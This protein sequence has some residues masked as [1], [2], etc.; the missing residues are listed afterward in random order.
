MHTRGTSLWIALKNSLVLIRAGPHFLLCQH[1]ASAH[2]APFRVSSTSYSGAVQ[3]KDLEGVFILFEVYKCTW[4]VLLERDTVW[5]CDINERDKA[6][7]PGT[8]YFEESKKEQRRLWTSATY[9]IILFF[10][11]Q[12]RS[13]S[14][15]FDEV[16]KMWFDCRDLEHMFN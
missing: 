11:K 4:S 5:F 2:R 1:S 16:G 15:Y 13:T 10:W 14:K 12:E 7:M 8:P 9:Q 3:A 6:R